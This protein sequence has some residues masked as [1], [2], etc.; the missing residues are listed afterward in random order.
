VNPATGTPD[1]TAL[2]LAFIS[3]RPLNWTPMLLRAG[4][5][6]PLRVRFC[7]FPLRSFHWVNCPFFTTRDPAA[8]ESYQAT[9]APE[10]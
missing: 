6:Y 9:Q 2:Q 8:E 3:L 7:L 10:V 4:G 5:T 1:G